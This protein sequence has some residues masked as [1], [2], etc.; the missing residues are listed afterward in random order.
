MPTKRILVF[1]LDGTLIDTMTE[2]ADLFCEMLQREHGV[3]E[4]VS[5][6]VYVELTGKRAAAPI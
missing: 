6:P 2:L 1:D 3:A 4:A 5:R